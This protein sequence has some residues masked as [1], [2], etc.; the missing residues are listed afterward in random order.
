[1]SQLLSFERLK[2]AAGVVLL[3]PY[4]PLLFMGEE[5]GED[6]PFLYFVSHSDAELIEAVRNGRKE[7]FKAFHWQHE[8]PDRRAWKHFCARSCSGKKREGERHLILLNFYKNLIKLRRDIPALSYLDKDS[9]EVNELGKIILMQ[10]CKMEDHSHVLCIF[11][12]NHTDTTLPAGAPEG[13]WKKILDSSETIG[14]GSGT[15]LPEQINSDEKLT[16]R[17]NACAVFVKD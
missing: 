16:L 11:N 6:A 1:L 7:E 15:W 5:Y 4:V 13:K 17:A 2:L 10:R 12:F 8:P 9:L 3:S 14:G